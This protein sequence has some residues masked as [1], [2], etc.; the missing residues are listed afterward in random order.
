[1][2]NN[3]DKKFKKIGYEK[4]YESEGIVEYEKN[5]P[6]YNYVHCIDICHKASGEHIIQS[7][8][9]KINSDNFNNSVGMTYIEMKLALKK[10]K[11]KGWK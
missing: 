7:Y 4:V 5:I 8:E 6:R 10:M 2:F 3:I 1:M 9:K 11:Q